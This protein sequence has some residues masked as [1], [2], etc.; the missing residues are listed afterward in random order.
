[1]VVVMVVV[2]LVEVVLVLAV[3]VWVL[4]L[5][6]LL[7]ALL[8]AVMVLMVFV[9]VLLSVSVLMSIAVLYRTPAGMPRPPSPSRVARNEGRFLTSR[10]PSWCGARPV[11]SAADRLRT[12]SCCRLAYPLLCGAR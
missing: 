1:M 3:V 12:P 2:M 5:V 9:S 8:L 10:Q 7:L 4:L 11:Y 6:A